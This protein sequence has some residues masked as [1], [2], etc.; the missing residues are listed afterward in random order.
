[1]TLVEFLNPVR[2]SSNRDKCLAVL[3]YKHR[4][5]QVESLTADEIKKALIQCR[6]P[7]A[8]FTNVADVLAKSGAMVDSPAARGLAR[9]W[10]LTGKGEIHVRQVM[11]LTEAE[12]EIEHDVSYL[13]TVV[14]KASDLLVR[15]YIEEAVDCL[16]IGALRAGVVFLWA[17]AVRTLQERVFTKGIAPVNAAIQIHDPKAR[18]IKK[19]D[20]FQYIKESILLLAAEGV[21]VV[22]KAERTTLEEN[23]NLRNKCGHPNKYDPGIKKASSFI[24]DVT[25]IVFS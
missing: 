24:E 9:L 14:V 3:Y 25:G 8:K 5:E 17:G 18:Q 7:N 10:R 13:K 23:L 19:L 22:D 15:A 4:Y 12:A 16:S 11:G 6:L 21:G 20:D 2:N 1:M